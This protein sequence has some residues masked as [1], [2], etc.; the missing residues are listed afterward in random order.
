[1]G[2]VGKMLVTA[3]SMWDIILQGHI[4]SVGGDALR[5]QVKMN[6]LYNVFVNVLF[7]HSCVQFPRPDK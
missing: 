3:T 4:L 6:V 5:D 2:G 1:M 7:K